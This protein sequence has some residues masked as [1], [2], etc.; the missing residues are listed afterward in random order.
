MRRLLFAAGLALATALPALADGSRAALAIPDLAYRERVLGNGLQVLS[1]E[2]HDSPT[3]AVQ[4][5]YRVGSKDDPEGRS[6]FAHLFEHLMFKGTK[7]LAPEQF[8]RLT[9]DVGG[10]NNA[11][12]SD[13][14]TR[15]FEIVPSN[16]L[17]RLIWAEAERL[18][19]LKVDE[20]NFKSERAVVEEEYRQSV[21]AQPY[22]R[23]QL[24]LQ[25]ASYSTHPYHRPTIGSIDDLEAAS[26]ADV[27][28]FHQRYYRP[29]NATLIVVGDFD[30]KQLDGW[31]D[32]SFGVIPKPAE[33]I[34]HVEVVEPPRSADRRLTER[35]P[36]V[37]LPAL[38]ITWL[39]PP[40]RSSDS[41][42]L[43]VAAALLGG[44]E[45]SRLHQSLVYR[46]RIAQDASFDFDDL[47][48][49]GTLVATAVLANGRKPAEA[50]RALLAE[51]ERLRT[52]PIAEAELEKAKNQLLTSELLARETNQGKGFALGHAVIA[53]G[54]AAQANR[55]L[56]DLQAV[57]AADVQR[58]LKTYVSDQRKVVLEYLAASTAT[59]AAGAAR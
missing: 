27:V 35:A 9:E 52:R 56:K 31:I 14:T 38:G 33:A 34:P 7:H 59:D 48:D 46:A 28:A 8:D 54:D 40:A 15:Y 6:G 5:W 47:S 51:I 42:A 4:V 36:N 21:L 2:N 45:S 13:D 37:P 55:A 26:L 25:K 29:D 19:N 23:F 20:A 24:A 16:H 58:V 10:A 1:I 22:G 18:A 57:S 30:P 17:E 32:R 12:T 44:G 3:V 39:A 49:G 53:T 11:S 41:A 50:E 43:T